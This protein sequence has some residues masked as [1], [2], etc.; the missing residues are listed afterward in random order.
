MSQRH[1]AAPS[2]SC[3]ITPT[4]PQ[5]AND[6]GSDHAD[7][8]DRP[9]DLSFS[10]PVLQT[11][12]Y[13]PYFARHPG[14]R[15]MHKALCNNRDMLI[16]RPRLSRKMGGDSD[17]WLGWRGYCSR[18]VIV[19]LLSVTLLTGFLCGQVFLGHEPPN[20]QLS[21]T[22]VSR[23]PVGEIR[24]LAMRLSEGRLS[25]RCMRRCRPCLLHRALQLLAQEGPQRS[26]C[27]G[28]GLD[29]L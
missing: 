3:R 28:G 24:R 8:P 10:Y 27:I 18:C 15:I 25:H 22:R 9:S 12:C 6:T 16:L 20:R 11:S 26:S 23:L 5:R 2:E 4:S 13:T 7:R 1:C 21:L 19:S 17:D 14:R 29:L